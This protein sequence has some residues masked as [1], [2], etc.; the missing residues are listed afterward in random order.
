MKKIL[1]GFLFLLGAAEIFLPLAFAVRRHAFDPIFARAFD[2]SKFTEEQQQV[3]QQFRIVAAHDWNVVLYFGMATILI[4]IL[5]LV[6]DS[7]RKPDA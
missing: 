4:A 1:I 5:F 7:K 3:Y 2:F 6:S